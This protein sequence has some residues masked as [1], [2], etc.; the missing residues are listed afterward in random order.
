MNVSTA[1]LCTVIKRH[2]V[3]LQDVGMVSGIMSVDAC[4]TKCVV[5]ESAV[6]SFRK[7]DCS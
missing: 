5:N 7:M 1:H 6:A 2:H 3:L 4:T